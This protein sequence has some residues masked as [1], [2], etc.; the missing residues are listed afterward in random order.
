MW[1]HDPVTFFLQN[2]CLIVTKNNKRFT[3]PGEGETAQ[4]NLMGGK[5]IK[6][7]FQR[8][9]HGVVAQLFQMKG[10]VTQESIPPCIESILTEYKDIFEDT[11]CL[12]PPRYIEHG[13]QLKAG[14]LLVQQRPYRVPIH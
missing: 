11:K 3:I 6:N 13:I 10:E 14:A 4:L 9:R 2:N 1:D 8:T 5:C 7:F 12:P